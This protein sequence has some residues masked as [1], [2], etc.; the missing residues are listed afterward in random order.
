MFFFWLYITL[1]T[2][3]IWQLIN[4]NAAKKLK[5]R[6]QSFVLLLFF[7]VSCLAQ[8]S[9]GPRHQ[10][11]AKKFDK[12]VLEKFKNTETIF[13]LSETLD[14]YQSLKILEDSWDVTPYQ[15]V[16]IGDFD[17]EKYLNEKYSFAK[18]G[19]FLR[20]SSL[21]KGSYTT[22]FTYIDFI[23]Y[24]NEAIL[25]K[26]K[27][28][29]PKRWEKKRMDIL[30]ENELKIARIYIFPKSDFIHTTMSKS[31]DE[32]FVSMYVDDV[33]YNYKPGFLKNYFQKVNSLIRDEKV[34]WMYGSDYEEELQNLATRK[35]YI[36]SYLSVKYNAWIARDGEEDEEN[37]EDV[38]KKYDYPYEIIDDTELSERIMNNE[39]LYYIRY[40]RMNAE[41]FLQ[42]VNSKNGEIVY[43]DYIP[44]FG[45]RIKSS[46]IK[47][48][49]RD[50]ARAAK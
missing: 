41:K 2:Q 6:I 20:T 23:M 11:R 16:H 34:Y 18:L 12:G 35:L 26:Q 38:F 13:I 29:S 21:G 8:V 31:M 9:V 49:N 10:G 27:K 33:F 3:L 39:E 28:L 15:L 42:I 40:V 4:K 50:I 17:P 46:H 5:M 25:K 45:Y 32:T 30:E 44:G 37:I 36:P 7:S 1:I 14:R 48:L 47:D 43:R 19:G 24:D 22:L